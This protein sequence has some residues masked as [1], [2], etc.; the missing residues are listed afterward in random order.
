MIYASQ[1]KLTVY[2]C[3]PNVTFFYGKQ[4]FKKNIKSKRL[5]NIIDVSH[6]FSWTLIKLCRTYQSV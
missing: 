5:Q 4:S 2:P 6:S 3:K 1:I